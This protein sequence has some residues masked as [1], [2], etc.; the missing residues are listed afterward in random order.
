MQPS[1]VFASNNTYKTTSNKISN[2]TSACDGSPRRSSERREAYLIESRSVINRRTVTRESKSSSTSSNNPTGRSSYDD[3]SCAERSSTSQNN[4]PPP[5]TTR[6]RQDSSTVAVN[7]LF[8]EQENAGIAADRLQRQSSGAA[9]RLIRD[10]A[11]LRWESKA[12]RIDDQKRAERFKSS[13]SSSSSRSPVRTASIERIWQSIEEPRPPRL[14]LRRI[15]RFEPE[16]GSPSSADKSSSS[17]RRSRTS[18]CD[19]GAVDA[20]AVPTE[21]GVHGQNTLLEDKDEYSLLEIEVPKCGLGLGFC[22]DGGKDGPYGDRPITVKR[23]F[24]GE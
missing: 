22:I 19:G 2:H 10:E 3:G 12:T 1:A 8:P 9:I 17:R 7:K 18:S 6:G 11:N 23:L 20:D 14:L 16:P 4:E 21:N 15:R 5:T 24:R 13:S